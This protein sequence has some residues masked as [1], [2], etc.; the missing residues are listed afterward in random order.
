MTVGAT[1]DVPAL[2]AIASRFP[3]VKLVVLFGS[4][5]RGQALPTSD[6]D[7]AVLGSSFWSGLSLGAELGRALGREPHV[8]EL[9]TASDLRRM[10]VVR[11]G[12]LIYERE[13]DVW[14]RFKAESLVRWLDIAPMV[15]LC[16]AGVRKRLLAEARRG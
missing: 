6:A 8:V 2:A 10:Q 1:L 16:A 3:E 13:P 7:F 5:A 4:V 12:T 14:V 9:E 15:E 11:D